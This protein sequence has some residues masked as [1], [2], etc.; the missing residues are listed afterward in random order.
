MFLAGSIELN[1]DTLQE[2]QALVALIDEQL[3]RRRPR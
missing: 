2:T 3:A 1:T